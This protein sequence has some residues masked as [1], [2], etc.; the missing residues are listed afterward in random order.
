MQ[1]ADY[2]RPS[3]ATLCCHPLLN[4]KTHLLAAAQDIAEG[5]EG[6]DAADLGVLVDRAVQL[7]ARRHFSTASGSAATFFMASGPALAA[8]VGREREQ[9]GRS[10]VKVPVGKAVP[11]SPLDGE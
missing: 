1:V 3:L 8:S 7:A 6:Y 10:T 9:D 2:L 5:A 11:E 4:G